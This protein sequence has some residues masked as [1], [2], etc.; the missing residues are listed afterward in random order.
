MSLARKRKTDRAESPALPHA[1]Q[2]TA[3]EDEKVGRAGKLSTKPN[4]LADVQRRSPIPRVQSAAIHREHITSYAVALGLTVV[5]FAVRFWRIS[6][7]NQVVF[8]EVHFGAFAGQYLRREYYFDVHPPLA[9]MLNAL[10]GWW[11]GFDGQFGFDQIGDN[12][13]TA[14]VPYVGM[15]SFCAILGAVTVPLVYAIMRESGYPVAIAAFSAS[16]ILFGEQLRR[17]YRSFD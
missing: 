1:I 3:S 11:V 10:A 12:Y 7:P 15:R 9:K 14:N 8:D 2:R 6:H 5:A 17:G 4:I 16:L 13:L